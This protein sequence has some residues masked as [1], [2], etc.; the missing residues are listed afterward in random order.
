M[1][2]KR[3]DPL[4]SLC[5]LA[6]LRQGFGGSLSLTREREAGRVGRAG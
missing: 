1:S 2:R 4:Y 5:L 3:R 6:R